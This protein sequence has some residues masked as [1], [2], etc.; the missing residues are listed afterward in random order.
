MGLIFLIILIVL[1]VLYI[2]LQARVSDIE[3]ML[4]RGKF[5]NVGKETSV[6][7]RDES[8]ND[9]APEG[10]GAPVPPSVRNVESTPE[11]HPEYGETLDDKV[12]AWIKEDWLMK[13]G[14]LLVL[15]AVAW[16]VTYAFSHG[17][18]TP[19]WRILLGVIAGIVVMGLGW[20]RMTVSRYQGSVFTVL[21]GTIVLLSLFAGRALYDLFTPA[22]AL[23]AMAVT[24]GFV[25]YVSVHFKVKWL[26]VA[27]LIL[28][29]LAPMLVSSPEP[30][31]IGLFSYLLVV[32]IATLSVAYY[33]N[34]RGL[35]GL[36]LILVAYYS[37]AGFGSEVANVLLYF[38]YIFTVIFF[39][40]S[41]IE[42]LKRES[43]NVVPDLLT[44]FGTGIFIL[45]WVLAAGSAGFQSLILLAWAVA[46]FFG[47]YFTYDLTKQKEPFYTY[48]A[49][50]AT[51]L[52]VAFAL[53]VDG[54]ALIIALTAEAALLTI[55][56]YYIT[57]SRKTMNEISWV[58]IVPTIGVFV[59]FMS[60]VV[61]SDGV[62][63]QEFFS[64]AFFILV[65]LGMNAFLTR[66][67]GQDD[68]ED[69]KNVGRAFIILASFSAYFLY[70]VFFAKLVESSALLAIL[71][72]LLN[73][74]T[75]FGI[76]LGTHKAQVTRSASLLLIIPF[77]MTLPQFA[78]YAG[79]S[80]GL[81]S[82]FDEH[83]FALLVYALALLGVGVFFRHCQGKHEA[84]NIQLSSSLFIASVLYGLALIWMLFHQV[85]VSDDI[86]VM[87]SLASYT[88]F[89]IVAYFVGL[90]EEK[91][92][93]RDCGAILLLFVVAR[94]LLVD[95]WNMEVI[96]RMVTFLFVGV[97]FIATAFLTKRQQIV[98]SEGSEKVNE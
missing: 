83:F 31:F 56:T 64:I 84:K 3:H 71:I 49:V 53:E 4:R 79:G 66:F 37:L 38:A 11:R 78:L 46:F 28:A 85:L 20:W 52:A 26:S 13:L 22:L 45:V 7:K 12:V 77:L 91:R 36:A 24:A 41:T 90:F 55:A 96:A 62:F 29:G 6:P 9:I 19:L 8:V 32:V 70:W 88:V 17:W 81:V 18:I 74:I 15:L 23:T 69:D 14:A 61:S 80:Q 67:I 40:T 50:A 57:E 87:F 39:A 51:F 54:A 2:N 1:V 25:A 86:A 35:T 48:G 60:Y 89:G 27:G 82:A 63:S 95:V 68:D 93:L 16:F 10:G 98:E 97:L 75:I 5:W 47:A 58:F 92:V 76:Y 44:A 72:T 65:T 94:L 33:S 21:G 30:N 73:V 59:S 43:K 42:I 34:F